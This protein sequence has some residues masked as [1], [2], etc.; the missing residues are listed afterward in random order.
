MTKEVEFEP[1]EKLIEIDSGTPIIVTEQE[2]ITF[3]SFL[4]DY[5]P[6]FVLLMTYCEVRKCSYL[7]VLKI[8]NKVE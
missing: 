3:A 1:S 2:R 5:D 4:S 8:Y 7:K 6:S